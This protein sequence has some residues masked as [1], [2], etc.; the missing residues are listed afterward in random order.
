MSCGP[1]EGIRRGVPL[2]LQDETR[3]RCLSKEI[4]VMGL[5]VSRIGGVSF[6][7]A[8]CTGDLVEAETATNGMVRT[9]WVKVTSV[10]AVSQDD[11]PVRNKAVQ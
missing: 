2:K 6:A 1:P 11:F 10:P 8:D 7:L 3:Q 5:A 4:G 9:N